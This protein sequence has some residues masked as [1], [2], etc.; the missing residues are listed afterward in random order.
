MNRLSGALRELVRLDGGAQVR[1]TYT[2]AFPRIRFV[3]ADRVVWLSFSRAG[4]REVRVNLVLRSL[5]ESDELP[6]FPSLEMH[7]GW[8]TREAP[9]PWMRPV[10]SC[11]AAL[12]ARFAIYSQNGHPVAHVLPGRVRDAILRLHYS[13]RKPGVSLVI[14]GRS[15]GVTKQFVTRAVTAGRLRDLLD[16][17]SFLFEEL[18]EQFRIDPRGVQEVHSGAASLRE[19]HCRVCGEPFESAPV[20]CVTCETPHHRDCW[21]YLGRCAIFA[22]GAVRSTSRQIELA[23]A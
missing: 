4:L 12:D 9:V 19:S 18:Q 14:G 2:D 1:D 6:G 16:S 13:Q 21:D 5:L 22:C 8:M 3:S 17:G 20:F 23:S 10:Q 7:P 15:V 11:D